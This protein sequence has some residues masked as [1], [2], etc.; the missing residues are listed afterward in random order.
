MYYPL[1][2]NVYQTLTHT[3][4]LMGYDL[5]MVPVS[6]TRASSFCTLVIYTTTMNFKWNAD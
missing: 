5:K 3:H 1:F 6:V 2:R 4:F